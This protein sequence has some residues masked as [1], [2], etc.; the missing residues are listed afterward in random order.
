M[1]HAYKTG[2][3]RKI[4]GEEHH[5]HKLTQEDVEYIR[6]VYSKR[7]PKYGAVAL[8]N[9]FGV[10]RTTIHDIVNRKTWRQI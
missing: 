7:D 8:S 3:E 6:S 10:D 4:F 5:N 9:K 1:I 2:L